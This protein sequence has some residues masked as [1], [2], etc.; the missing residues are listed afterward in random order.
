MPSDDHKH[1]ASEGFALLASISCALLRGCSSANSKLE[2][3]S[4]LRGT[5]SAC[6][7][8]VR[9]QLGLPYLIAMLSDNNSSVRAAAIRCVLYC[10][11]N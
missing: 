3:I 1:V 11:C 4:V 2:A 9:L 5:L 8:D 10:D 6:N 7:D